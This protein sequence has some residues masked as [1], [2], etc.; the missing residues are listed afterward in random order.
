M[1]SNIIF[2]LTIYNMIYGWSYTGPPLGGHRPLQCFSNFFDF[3]PLYTMEPSPFVLYLPLQVVVDLSLFLQYP[4]GTQNTILLFHRS[5]SNLVICPAY[6]F[7]S[8]LILYAN[9]PNF[10][11]FSYHTVSDLILPLDVQYV[12]L[13]M[14]LCSF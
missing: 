7:F 9:S 3:V 10:H 8:F 1:I 14:S 11:F 13:H 6:L 12:P 5:S 2:Y 4:Y